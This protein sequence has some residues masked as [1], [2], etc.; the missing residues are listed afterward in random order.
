MSKD[1]MQFIKPDRW[2]LYDVIDE[3]GET[4]SC[5]LAGW[6]TP[7][8]DSFNKVSNP[9]AQNY[10]RA[11]SA[12]VH[13]DEDDYNYYFYTEN[14]S[15]YVCAKAREG[16]TELTRRLWD[17]IKNAE[18]ADGNTAKLAPRNDAT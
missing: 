2:I 16:M 13:E 15:T 17:N 6:I 9:I 4:H 8:N 12:I 3:N 7:P 1:K 10:W 11:S 5:V 18:Y 14:V